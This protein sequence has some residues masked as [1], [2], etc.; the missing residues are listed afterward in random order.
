ML[1]SLFLDEVGGRSKSHRSGIGEHHRILL[2]ISIAVRIDVMTDANT[3][4]V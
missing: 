4:V 2:S 3:G 1:F